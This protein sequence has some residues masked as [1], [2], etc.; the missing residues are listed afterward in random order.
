MIHYLNLH[1]DPFNSIKTQ[2]KTV[3]MRL[4][5]ERRQNI[6]IGD[7]L[8]FTNIVTNKKISVEVLAK[9]SFTDFFELYKNFSK[10]EI[11]YLED[12]IADPNDMLKYYSQEKI[13]KYGA[14][15]ITI[16]LI[17]SKVIVFDMDDTMLKDDK[18]IS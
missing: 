5:D 7:I 12:E 4:N 6:T 15:A 9:E 16:K 18:T 3:E 10:T 13:D 8:V 2:Q 14:L 11:G 1:N 17:S